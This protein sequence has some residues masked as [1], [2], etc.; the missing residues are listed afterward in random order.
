MFKY[1]N[2]Y[3]D[4][5]LSSSDYTFISA[6]I[7]FVQL[8][9]GG[10]VD[11]YSEHLNFASDEQ[12]TMLRLVEYGVFPSYVL[13]GGS[14]YDLKRTNSSNVY[15]S[16]YDI[17][18]TRMD[19]YASFYNEGLTH[20]IQKE[21]IDHTFLAEGVVLVEYNDGSQILLNYNDSPITVETYDVAAYSYVVI[22]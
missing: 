19:N 6:S 13:T 7:P 3:Y 12:F 17:L 5:P 1:L 11:M 10:S 20:Q 22:S 14:T 15:I 8:V 16:E 4:A 9:I 21:M 18:K 2:S